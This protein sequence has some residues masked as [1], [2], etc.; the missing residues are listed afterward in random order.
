VAGAL[1][2]YGPS[3]VELYRRAATFVDKIFKGEKPGDLPIEQA[4][5]YGLI[6]NFST[7]YPELAA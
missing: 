3:R 4:T 5:K 1:I 6:I 7:S 2:A